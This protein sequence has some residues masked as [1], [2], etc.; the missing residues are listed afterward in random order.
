MNSKIANVIALELGI[1]IAITA[2]LTFSRLPG[3]EEQSAA[4][5]PE[6]IADSL[7]TATPA[8]KSRHQHLYAV[9]YPTNS[10]VEQ[11]ANEEQTQTVQDYDQE[12]ATE[13]YVSPDL[14]DGV[15]TGSSPSYTEV[16]PEPVVYPPDYFVAPP[17]PVVAYIQPYEIIVFSNSHPLG[18]RHRPPPA[19]VPA[20]R[21]PPFVPG[22]G[23]PV[24]HR[25][26]A[27]GESHPAGGGNGAG[28]V[29][30]GNA[31]PRPSLP[32]RGSQT[33]LKSLVRN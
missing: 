14:N 3:K 1:L 19:C 7:A 15:I 23:P 9:D 2:W 17:T 11:P 27:R 6:R 26:P 4:A 20:V 24:G 10:A 12:I 21:P 25:P 5:E 16:E 31:H 32:A 30:S 18:C 33:P 28:V 22:A 13:P 29:P 8:P